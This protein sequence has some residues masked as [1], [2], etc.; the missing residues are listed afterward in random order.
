MNFQ[1][2]KQVDPNKIFL[3]KCSELEGRFDPNTY[4][5]NR[6]K[7][8]SK[9]KESKFSINPLGQ[10]ASFTKIVTTSV[11]NDDIYI[12][13]ENIE[14]NTGVFVETDTK[15]TV[16]SALKFKKGQV[17]F[18]KLRPYLNKVHY[19]NFDGICS[20][21]FHLLDSEVLDNKFLAYFLGLNIV[22]VQ[23][24]LLMSGNTLPRLQTDDIKK[25][26]VPIPPKEIQ[27]KIVAKMD[28]VY[29]VKK[30]KEQQAKQLL[31]SIDDYLLTELGIV[32]PEAIDNNL[33][34]RIFAR[35]LS[36]VSSR[37]LDPKFHLINRHDKQGKYEFFTLKTLATIQKGNSI[38]KQDI[39]DGDIPVI[40][41]GQTSPYNHRFANYDGDVITVSASGYAGYVWYHSNPIF[42]SDCTVIFSDDNTRLNNYYLF[43]YLKLE[44]QHI[45]NLQQGA[46]QPHIYPS[47][48]EKIRIPL[49][50]LAKQTKI[51]NHISQI[52][53]K[54]K[55]LQTDAKTELEN[56]KQHVEKMIL[57]DG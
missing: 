21:E 22:V 12:G 26:P 52:R 36:E 16:S 13:L 15:E 47:D 5:P 17:L 1:L 54:A 4:H 9:I 44:Q 28:A 32:L 25:L 40:A 50:P 29:Q 38:T 45:Y 27:V 34:S 55:Q 56:A 20:T 39:I 33:Q 24:T 19:T 30:D 57:N 11:A 49:P 42:A 37:R 53:A 23:T 3:V 14:S 51:A 35:N 46:V 48:L 8:I 6:I 2:S 31:D 10:I 41:G 7:V 43:E 18:P